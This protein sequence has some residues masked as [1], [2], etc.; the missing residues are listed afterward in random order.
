MNEVNLTPVPMRYSG[1]RLR[2]PAQV[3]AGSY[4]TLPEKALLLSALLNQAGIPACPAAVLRAS[5]YD[6]R[7]ADLSGIE[8]MIVKA[9]IP[10]GDVM[11]LSAAALNPQDLSRTLDGKVAVCFTGNGKVA[12]TKMDAKEAG[13]TLKGNLFVSDKNEMTGEVSASLT[14]PANPQYALKRDSEKARQWFAGGVASR[15]LKDAKFSQ[16][17]PESANFAFDI[18]KENAL[19]KDSI[20]RIFTLPS[21][22]AGAES[23]NLKLLPSYRNSP[24][25]VP[26]ALAETTELTVTLPDGMTMITPEN[27]FNISNAAGSFRFVLKKEAGKIVVSRELK[28]PSRIIEPGNYQAFKT[29]LDNY[30]DPR[31]RDIL[32]R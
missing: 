14:G 5:A 31:N 10:G 20:L 6:G 4:G 12:E 16:A 25:E 15:D 1:F 13:V 2:T 27:E 30:N 11:W 17:G 21:L 3:W 18:K 22:T 26:F 8:E 23:W 29:L 32:L 24:L 7:I 9:E 28:I 19:K